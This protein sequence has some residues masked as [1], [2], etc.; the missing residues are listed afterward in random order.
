[1]KRVIVYL[2]L[3]GSF[4]ST[5]L[6][7]TRHAIPNMASYREKIRRKWHGFWIKNALDGA[8][9]RYFWEADVRKKVAGFM[10]LLSPMESRML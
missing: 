10:I 6:L 7:F 1:M 3:A 9:G 4:S 5:C 2:S 8:A